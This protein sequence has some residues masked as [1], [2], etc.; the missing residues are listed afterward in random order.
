M[1][2]PRSVYDGLTAAVNDLSAKSREL[3]LARFNDGAGEFV[4]ADG[5]VPPENVAALREYAIALLDD[6]G[7]AA[8]ELAFA[9]GVDGYDAARAAAVGASLG[10]S[11]AVPSPHVANERAVRGMVDAVKKTG[12]IAAFADAC[13]G[14]V[15][16][17][18]RKSCGDAVV[19][20]A[21]R[22]PLKP[23]FARVPQGRETCSFCIMLASRGAVYEN[24][25]TAGATRHYHENCD[26][27][28]VPDFGDGIDGYDPDEYYE[29][30]RSDVLKEEE[31][32]KRAI[33]REW[34]EFRKY[35]TEE[36]YFETLGKYIRSFS[37][38]GLIDCEFRAKP[39]A[40]E[41]M[42]A[43]SLAKNG[44]R[45]V[46]R[47]E[48]GGAENNPDSYVDGEICDFKR[49]T[50]GNKSK[51][52]QRLEESDQAEFYVIDLRISKIIEAAAIE[53]ADHAV[54]SDSVK[55]R[56][57]LLLF[58]DGSETPIE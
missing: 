32:I 50:S 23:R 42:T 39:N 48:V 41:L 46:F 15:D 47:K 45:V 43:Q 8:S 9:Y 20:C 25:M 30:W 13:A 29:L 26:C 53:V 51:I 31:S 58:A 5:A 16:Y 18:A 54:S 27:K 36:A 24:A 52:Y 55:A 1:Q 6:V 28:V 56:N 44:H 19:A 35:D 7:G 12:E 38:D 33:N 34:A 11:P 22:D 14:R 17:I 40:K 37:K 57:V 21:A 49:I 2:V 4:D 3:F 10:A